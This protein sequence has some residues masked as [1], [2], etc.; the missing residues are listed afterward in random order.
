MVCISLNYLNSMYLYVS[1]NDSSWVCLNNAGYIQNYLA[2]KVMIMSCDIPVSPNR[3]NSN[4]IP[5][6]CRTNISIPLKYHYIRLDTIK[7]HYCKSPARW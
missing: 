1:I 2:E 4:K 6:Y 7:Y 5:S 3:I